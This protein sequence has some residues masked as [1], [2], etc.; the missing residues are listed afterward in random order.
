MSHFLV[1]YEIQLEE[2]I[3]VYVKVSCS[4]AGQFSTSSPVHNFIS[5]YDTDNLEMKTALHEG[6]DIKCRFS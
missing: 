6:Q 1:L 4:H 2:N 3:S 5:I